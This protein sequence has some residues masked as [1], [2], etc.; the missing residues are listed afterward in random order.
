[1]PNVSWHK[2]EIALLQ[3]NYQLAALEQVQLQIELNLRMDSSDEAHGFHN[4]IRELLRAVR[5]AIKE[6][7]KLEADP[8]RFWSQWMVEL[9]LWA[10]K[11][12]LK[13]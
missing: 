1:M 6:T 11:E 4:N 8:R 3:L 5:I 10:T 13:V 9:Y 7:K 2:K 12:R